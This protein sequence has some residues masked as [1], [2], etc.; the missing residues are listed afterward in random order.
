[1]ASPDHRKQRQQHELEI[2]DPPSTTIPLAIAFG[3]YTENIDMDTG[4]N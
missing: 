4:G 3:D 1:M 2:M